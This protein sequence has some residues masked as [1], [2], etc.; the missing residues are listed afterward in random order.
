MESP[1]AS[2]FAF[3]FMSSVA[4]VKQASGVLY[5]VTLLNLLNCL[6]PPNISPQYSNTIKE[7]EQES[8]TKAVQAVHFHTYKPT[9][10]G[11]GPL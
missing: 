7:Y 8:E 3:A 10:D 5:S 9:N 2:A 1:R 4:R 11:S 6:K